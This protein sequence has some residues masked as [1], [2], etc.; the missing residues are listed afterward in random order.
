MGHS[1][2][3]KARSRERILE[4]AGERLRG[5]GIDG[6][7]VAEIMREAGLTHGGFYK[8]FGSR[9]ELVREALTTAF[10][11]QSVETRAAVAASDAPL[12]TF[13]DRYTSAEHC[14]HPEHGCAVAAVATEVARGGPELRAAYTERIGRAVAYLE[15]LLAEAHPE[16]DAATQRPEAIARY[17]MLVGGVTLARAVD[18]DALRGEILAA[19]RHAAT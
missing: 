3:E 12:E 17:A 10:D 1:K 5:Q 7:G 16:A 4:V 19:V 9:D 14:A 15:E 13:V 11:E 2:T 18:D 6:P 8:H